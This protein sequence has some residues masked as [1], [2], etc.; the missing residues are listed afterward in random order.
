MKRTYILILFL[1]FSLITGCGKKE[2]NAIET[3]E[4]FVY[5]GKVAEVNENDNFVLSNG[6][7]L[8][9]DNNE[10]FEVSF[11]KIYSN[12]T[13]FK[14]IVLPDYT[15]SK[16]VGFDKVSSIIKLFDEAKQCWVYN[17][18][19]I[20]K[21]PY[22]IEKGAPCSR[23]Y[24][25]YSYDDNYLQ[26]IKNIELYNTSTAN[27]KGDGLSLYLSDDKLYSIVYMRGR[28]YKNESKIVDVS[29]IN[30]EKI[31]AIFLGGNRIKE[32]FYVKTNKSYYKYVV[33][34]VKLNKEECEKYADIECIIEE[35]PRLEKIDNL[36]KHYND[37]SFILDDKVVFKNG[38]YYKF[39]N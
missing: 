19:E 20:V 38:N 24:L 30:G 2:N 36:S 9:N 16:I 28:D 27:S 29:A 8:V 33:E 21:R 15:N 25:T 3:K 37:I 17:K 35:N 7:L 13:N 39:D 6:Q 12:E 14:K 31:I 18:Q 26:Q 32:K 34:N 23:D 22:I 10:V 5:L 11:D 1:L 4:G